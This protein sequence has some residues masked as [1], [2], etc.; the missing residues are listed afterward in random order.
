MIKKKIELLYKKLNKAKSKEDCAII[1]KEINDIQDD[2]KHDFEVEGK[3]KVC[4]HC[5]FMDVYIKRK[6]KSKK[7]EM[8]LF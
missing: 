4:K 5:D 6:R 3:Y 7:S 2:C 1:H 8:E